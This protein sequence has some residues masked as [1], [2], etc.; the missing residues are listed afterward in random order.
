MIGPYKLLEQIGEGGMGVVYMAEQ[1]HPVRRR[2]ALKLI[3][4]GMDSRQ[5]IARFDAERQA[6]AL[7]D[8]PN[9]ARILD[10]GMVGVD[11]EVRNSE[12]GMRSEEATRPNPQSAIRN[13]QSGCPFFVMELVRGVPIT[14]FCDKSRLSIRQRLELFATV[15]RAVQ[16]AH[17]K[18]IIH[19][20]IKPTN[21]LVTLNDGMPVPKVIDFGVAKAIHQ[22]LTE[23]TLHTGF[24]QMLGT[25][26]YMSPEQAEMSSLDIDTRS[27]VYSLGVLLYE[28][29]TGSTP[30]DR[31]T[32][33]K[34]GYDEFRRL[35]REVEPPIP[36]SRL[37]TLNAEAISTIATQR[38]SEPRK[39]GTLLRGELDW[40]VMKALEKDRNRRYESASALAA[41]VERHL[42]DEP[43]QACPPSAAYRLRKFVRRNKGPIAAAA[44][45]VLALV[46]G[47]I[48]T[49]WQA[50]R[51]TAAKTLAIFNETQADQ[52]RNK[53]KE[54]REIAVAVLDFLRIK[55]LLQADP[56]QQADD[57]ILAGDSPT[58]AKQNPTVRELL[59]RAADELR[60][61]KIEQ[62]FPNQPAVHAY[63]LHAIGQAYCG[64]GDYEAAI[65]H[66]TR[67]RTQ[68]NE[69]RGATHPD[70]L[71]TVEDLA[72]AYRESS[73]PFEAIR[74][75]ELVKAHRIESL[76]ADH[77]DTL[78]TFNNL[79]A[80]YIAVGQA[81]E[82]IPLLKHV[83]AKRIESLG[84]DDPGALINLANLATAYATAGDL[85]EALRLA[86]HVRDRQT[87]KLGP[88][89]PSTLRTTSDLASFCYEAGKLSEAIRLFE[90]VR[91]KQIEKLGADHPHTLHTL[92]SVA[93][94]Y[95]AAGDLSAAIRL[96]EQ[97]RDKQ[98]EKLGADHRGTLTTMFNLAIAYQDSGKFTEAL[99]L[100][101]EVRVGLT[102]KFGA[103]HRDT[104]RTLSGVAA[105][106][107][108]A[109]DLPAAIRLFEQVRDK[110]I[111]KLGAYHRE[112]VATLGN[113]AGA[114]HD[115]G[116]LSEAIR[117]Y[118]QV[119][120]TR[121]K[122][123]GADHPD[124]LQTLNNLACAYMDA[125][126]LSEAIRLLEQVKD[127]RIEQLGADHPDTL[128]TLNNLASAYRSAG[129]LSAAIQLFEQVCAKQR[130]VLGVDHP[131]TLV[132][133]NNLAM[134]HAYEGKF[135]EAIGLLEEVRVGLTEK[136]GADH[137]D[138]LKIMNN[139]AL[140]HWAVGKRSEAIRLYEQVRPKQIEKLGADHPETLKTL[141][142]LVVAYSDHGSHDL[143]EPLLRELLA[144]RRRILRPED[145]LI[146][147]SLAILATNL[148]EQKKFAE[149]ETVVRECLATREKIQP[150]EWTTSNTKS[151]LGGSLLGQKKYAE[152]EPL[153]LAGLEGM[154]NRDAKIPPPAKVRLTEALQRLVQ[155]YEETNK[156]EEAA[157]WRAELEKRQKSKEK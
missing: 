82:A 109:G 31:E 67:A 5:V 94:V 141:D 54:E 114:Y 13:P 27:D 71:D 23:R 103:D 123:F 2:V 75:N 55:L 51:A 21:V 110:Q 48:G 148:L 117:L 102:K 134:A 57:L 147:A 63:L 12:S 140:T 91:P 138:T 153:L 66:L 129:R 83:S 144:T 49:S 11:G 36:S 19:R 88:D 35:V 157:K 149:A 24:A 96:F 25:P 79:A 126:T 14:E 152:A 86:E 133:V 139:L 90:Q 154:L 38:G 20:D 18:G 41:D 3:K 151:L 17:Q 101:E 104:L 56:R 116:K 16:H 100:L 7:M 87:E 89:H 4:P 113:L 146:A 137:P 115:A 46:G 29:L 84:A 15:C 99:R 10:A 119:R 118:E 105:V 26:A 125:G 78:R 145:P 135:S 132:T 76:G 42:L 68:L 59:D 136:F 28:L 155:L 131:Q 44:L 121:M 61:D 127:G 81:D 1:H 95:R 120:E 73:N 60:P 39:L 77:L 32:L 93:A 97:V 58:D 156:P 43:V 50:M 124:T 65:N 8:H 6:L 62:H 70:T 52:E 85:S 30:F 143:A 150:D 80:A 74:L 64:I 45:V 111:D 40:L 107:R 98:I 9:I 122:K 72:I 37:S 33:R 34:A 142:N 108:T 128:Q 112:T 53:A 47:I 69:Q 22:Q 92:S 130:K 106:Y